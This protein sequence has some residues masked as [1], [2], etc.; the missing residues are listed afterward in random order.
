[1]PLTFKIL[2]GSIALV[3]AFH[4][5]FALQETR[6]DI[7][8]FE[9]FFRKKSQD[10]VEELLVQGETR[11][12]QMVQQGDAV[13][14]ARIRKEL[15]LIH[16]TGTNSYE[17]AMDFFIEALALE[18]SLGLKSEKVFT[19]MAIA[20]VFEEVGN[21]HKS[22]EF[23]EQALELNRPLNDRD[24]EV[25]I[26]NK[27]GK[28]YAARGDIE[29]AF[30][31][32][33]L[34]LEYK[35][36]IDQPGTEAEALR[37]IARLYAMQG[38][39]N[40]ALD[41]H[42]QALKIWRSLRDKVNEAVSLNDIGELYRTTKNNERA[43]ANHEAAL[44]IRLTINDKEGIAE[45]YN[46]IGILYYQQKDYQRAIENLTHALDAGREAQAQERMRTSYDYLTLCYR[47]LGDYKKAYEYKDLYA[48]ISDFI[49]N[50]RNERQ[51]LETQN[52]YVV[53]KKQL[54]IEQLETIRAQ[55]EQE[56]R[57]QKQV[58]NFLFVVA[59]LSLVVVVLTLFLYVTKQRT[60]KA[61]QVINRKMQQQNTELQALNATKDKFFSIISHDLKGPL[62]SLTSFSGLLINH[63]DS[64]SKEEIK[65]LASDLDKSLKNLFALLENLLEWSRAQTGSIEFKP[66][67]FDL[68]VLLEE[69]AQLLHAQAKNKNIEIENA[70]KESLPVFA[71]KHSVNTVIRNLVSNA[72][73]FT[74][75][76]G[77]I[78]LQAEA[79]TNEI[80]VSVAD[81]GVGMS[82]EV[83]QKL[84][85]LDVKHST[86]GT[87]NEKGT[88]LGLLL[89]KEFVQKNGGR[90]WLKSEEGKGSVFYFSLPVAK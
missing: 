40:K 2:P 33:A 46:R 70:N 26:L 22:C 23:L 31:N 1:M 10:Q 69:N 51:L 18:D 80:V 35:D 67:P 62:N 43:L 72:I 57:A 47:E 85:R 14:E 34:V 38:Q 4:L 20:C 3:F 89:C 60:N 79:G 49:Q 88:G 6:P 36:Q 63:T 41:H 45:S 42:K 87:A 61:L 83:T 68:A 11:L 39:Y 27:L 37:N 24:M 15:G 21:F 74:P 28:I 77:K 52:R 90:I 73:K 76:G 50:E 81:T 65:M 55:R 9:G 75:E 29:K 56:I 64:L 84:F 44:E 5:A 19:Y 53:D 58:R 25:L 48:A 17:R 16:L 32:Y 30:H 66:E 78:T 12:A 54:Q 86:K 82:A 71:H 13:A 59:V 7:E 8:W